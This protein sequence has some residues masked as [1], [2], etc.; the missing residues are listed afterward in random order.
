M[1]NTVKRTDAVAV[2]ESERTLIERSRRGDRE[3]FDSLIL[4]H[5]GSAYGLARRILNDECEAADLA[6]EAF[7]RAFLGIS[8]FR[9]QSAFRTWLY[10]IVINL[11]RN[12]LKVRTRERTRFSSLPGEDT[13]DGRPPGREIASAE[14]G[15]D[16]RAERREM[17]E[18]IEKAISR[19]P[20]EQ[21]EV[22]LLR[23]VDGLSYEEIAR[24][25]GHSPGT[26][27]S[28]LHRARMELQSQLR[29]TV[30]DEMQLS[31]TRT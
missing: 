9:G 19:L 23:D 30:E 21:R 2:T 12:R 28:R 22:V 20:D 17:K 15:P 7:V 24:A 25:T 10:S 8:K 6:Q 11:G 26:V 5:G 1:S 27:R 29:D 14:P 4:L 18:A 13:R 3:A 16:V 31:S